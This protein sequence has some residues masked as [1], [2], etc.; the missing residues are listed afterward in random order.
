MGANSTTSEKEEQSGGQVNANESQREGSV[1]CRQEQGPRLQT[2]S[3]KH[4]P[5][6]PRLRFERAASRKR[7]TLHI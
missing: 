3:A 2:P 1:K 5:V 7:E 4:S 6:H